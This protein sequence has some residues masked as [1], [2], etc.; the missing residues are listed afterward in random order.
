V[1]L[2]WFVE[3]E[4]EPVTELG[5]APNALLVL[6]PKAPFEP[7]PKALLVLPPNALF[8]LP[9]K[10]EDWPNALEPFDPAGEPMGF[11]PGMDPPAMPPASVTPGSP[12]CSSLKSWPVIGSL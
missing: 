6:P 8:E 10:A 7:P 3:E 2:A 1:L 4:F 12:K 9:P 11:A 5:L